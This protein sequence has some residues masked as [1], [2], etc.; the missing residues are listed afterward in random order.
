MQAFIGLLQTNCQE[1]LD[2]RGRDYLERMENAATRMRTLIKD[3]LTLS[4]VTTK[5]QPFV[6]VDLAKVAYEVMTDLEVS[7]SQVEGH[8]EIGSLPTVEADPTQMRQLLQNLIGNALKFHCQD[9]APRVTVSG[10]PVPNGKMGQIGN[11]PDIPQSWQ[12]VVTD[13]GIGFDEKYVEQIFQPFRRLHGRGEYDGTGMGLAICRKIAERHSGT[14]TAA[15]TP[16]RGATFLI[17]LPSC[18]PKYKDKERITQ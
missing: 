7:I 18:P 2:E 15:S 5:G 11:S 10:R 17:T 13:N 4:R 14:I 12:I 16:G 6:P 8:F 1:A 3:L 9:E